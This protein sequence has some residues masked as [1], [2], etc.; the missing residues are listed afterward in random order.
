MSGCFA[1]A[2]LENE[3]TLGTADGKFSAGYGGHL[4]RGFSSE[5]THRSLTAPNA[6]FANQSS[7]FLS[8]SAKCRRGNTQNDGT[9]LQIANLMRIL[10]LEALIPKLIRLSDK[11]YVYLA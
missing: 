6:L 10:N 4:C 11:P 1:Q 2:S 9:V 8:Q 7:P 5:I 3:I